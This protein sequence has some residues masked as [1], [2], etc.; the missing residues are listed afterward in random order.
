[1][2]KPVPTLHPAHVGPSLPHNPL[3]E[4]QAT[5]SL[6]LPLAE[7][8]GREREPDY[9]ESVRFGSVRV[10][11]LESDWSSCRNGARPLPPDCLS[12]MNQ[13]KTHGSGPVPA[14][15]NC[16]EQWARVDGRIQP[17]RA[18]WVRY[19]QWI[20]LRGILCVMEPRGQEIKHR[21]AVSYL[22]TSGTIPNQ[23]LNIINKAIKP[24]PWRR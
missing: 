22:R 13:P 4:R 24:S 21:L 10:A 11:E 1:M 8:P 9:L 14:T 20:I 12:P 16:H 7:L 2:P 5:S 23:V 3:G 19:P 17:S 15:R 6:V 18:S